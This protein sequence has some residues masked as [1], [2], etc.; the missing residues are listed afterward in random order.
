[1]CTAKLVPLSNS[2]SNHP[3]P[4]TP[5][6]LPP[7]RACP[8]PPRER[9][10]GPARIGGRWCQGA[11]SRRVALSCLRKPLASGATGAPPSLFPPPTGRRR[12]Y[13]RANAHTSGSAQRGLCEHSPS[14][15]ALFAASP[16]R[17]LLA[18]SH[19]RIRSSPAVVPYPRPAVSHSHT[20]RPLPRR[21]RPLALAT[22]FPA[23]PH[24]PFLIQPPFFLIQ[25]PSSSSA[26]RKGGGG[27]ARAASHPF[28]RLALLQVGIGRGGGAPPLVNG[29][30]DERLAAPA[31]A[32]R[33]DA[34]RVGPVILCGRPR[35]RARVELCARA[36]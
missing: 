24:T 7:S 5:A 35:I 26:R 4:L 30:Y 13:P 3:P 8:T 20:H 32:R 22:S 28:R 6:S 27:D 21:C 36:G 15:R 11:Q 17:A 33:E 19:L 14:L 31:I 34:V 18:P 10:R 23:L 16:T 25:P 1:M 29:P 2:G 9:L 12:P